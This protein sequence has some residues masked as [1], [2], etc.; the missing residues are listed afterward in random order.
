MAR[1]TT[2]VDSML[3]PV[4]AFEY[5]AS[6]D[7]ASEWDPSV[8]EAR[9]LDSGALGMGSAF[10]IVS[11]F[12]GRSVPL[13]Y[14]ITEF[15]AGRRVVLE[16]WNGTFGS[17]DTITI[18][19]AGSAS[20]VTYDARLVF[21]GISRIADPLMQLVFNRVGRKAD[22]SLRTHLNRTR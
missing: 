10:R 9:R 12:A 6:F 21:K 22:A 13:R 16:A 3:S 15:D 11:K 19:P 20:T 8:V 1:Y 4:D 5:M 18:V 7:N 2:S 17:V 14:E